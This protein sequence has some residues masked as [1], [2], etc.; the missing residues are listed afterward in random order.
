MDTAMIE[1]HTPSSRASHEFAGLAAVFSVVVAVCILKSA[2]VLAHAFPSSENPKVGATIDKAPSAVAITYDSPIER[3]FARLAVSGPDGDDVTA[4]PAQ[5]DGG[6]RRLS[7][8][9]KPLGPGDYTVHW[10]VV[11]EDGHRTEGSYSFDVARISR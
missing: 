3:L 1:Q 5:V 4:G 10:S 11:A 7:V 8:P 6:G 9:L 2:P